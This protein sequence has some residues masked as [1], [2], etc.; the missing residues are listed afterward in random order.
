MV[1]CVKDEVELEEVEIDYDYGGVVVRGVKALRCPVCGEETIDLDQYEMI[2]R[3]LEAVI[4]PLR[5]RRKISA[6][7]R[8]P[9]LYMPEDV[10][11]APNLKIGDEVEIHMEGKRIVIEPIEEP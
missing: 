1:K 2:R 3:R 4:K 11:R 8:R 5:L 9:V 6:A 7:G 10:I